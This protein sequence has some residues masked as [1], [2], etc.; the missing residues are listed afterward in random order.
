[1]VIH[2]GLISTWE[3]LMS[4]L[5]EQYKGA[6]PTWLAPVQMKVIPV[7][8]DAHLAYAQKLHELFIDEDFRSELDVRDEKLGYKIRDAQTNKIPYQLVVGDNEVDS[9]QVT[10][11]RYGE[12]K[13]ATVS[14]EAFV[15]MVQE[16]IKNKG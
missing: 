13:Q 4:I 9:N 16:E 8:N 3:R 6:F 15:A 2:R 1:V 14:V 5:L 10:Y 7:N 11:R 12:K